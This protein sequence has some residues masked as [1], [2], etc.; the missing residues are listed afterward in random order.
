MIIDFI[1]HSSFSIETKTHQIII[2][3]F[4]GEIKKT[5]KQLLFIVTHSHS[6]H[7]SEKIFE[8]NNAKFA[9]SFDV[10]VPKHINYIKLEPFK[11]YIIDNI[12]LNCSAS[13]D[14][15]V[16]ILIKT[17]DKS[18]L[19][20]GDLNYWVWPEDTKEEKTKMIYNFKSYTDYFK[21][22]NIDIAIFPVDYRLEDNYD[23]GAIYI[24]ETIK[25]KAL[26]PAHFTNNEHILDKFKKEIE[27]K[28][29]I[30]IILPNIHKSINID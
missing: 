28:Y 22:N 5:D 4:D 12:E 26:I 24:I 3:Y 13:T 20:A 27:E 25:P 9:I 10:N 11:S 29:S 19:H 2:D 1:K 18:I 14:E 16:S 15:G 30:N 7:Y 8:Y 17:E 23:K 21:G 6:D